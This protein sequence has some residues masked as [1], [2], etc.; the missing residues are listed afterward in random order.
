MLV[1]QLSSTF[2]SGEN[3]LKDQA[4]LE[5]LSIL[6]KYLFLEY[7]KVERTIVL[8]SVFYSIIFFLW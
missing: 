5:N 8:L 3:M 1:F 7:W 2:E 4:F 6:Q